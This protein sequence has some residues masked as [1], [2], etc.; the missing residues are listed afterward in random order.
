MKS[1]Y[2]FRCSTGNTDSFKDKH[3]ANKSKK[4]H[5]VSLTGV[6][7]DDKSS[8]ESLNFGKHLNNFNIGTLTSI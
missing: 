2:N 4:G 1:F 6:T 3:P 5:L 8:S 7:T